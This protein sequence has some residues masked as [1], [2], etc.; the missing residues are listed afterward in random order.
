MT[1]ERAIADFLDISPDALIVIDATGKIALVNAQVE[2]IFGY[3]R[4]EL[5]NKP[6]EIL[7]PERFRAVHVTH[8]AHYFTSPRLRPMG[9]GLS[10]L[11]LRKNGQEFPVDI[12]LRPLD[13]SGVP[14]AIGAVRDMS[15]QRSAEQQV[16]ILR[17][18]QERYDTFLSMASH[19]LRTPLATMQVL[20]QLLSRMV[21]QGMER[22][23]E[24][25][26]RRETAREL[27]TEMFRQLERLNHLIGD[28]LDVSRV[29]AHQLSFDLEDIALYPLVVR[30]V[31]T[32]QKTTTTHTITVR[33]NGQKA[34]VVAD[35]HRIE[36]VLI[37]LLSNAI[38]YSPE[39]STVEVEVTRDTTNIT[40]HVRDH[41][42]GIASAQQAHLFERYYRLVDE[43]H[44]KYAGL[45]I[46]LYIASEIV[47]R[48]GGTM[49]V[50][51]AAGEG[52]IFS[53]TLP[54]ARKEHTL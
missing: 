12:S 3:S 44:K 35:P 13:L 46:G 16:V 22:S 51:S 50:E 20:T 19:E 17:E 38:K 41:G 24:Q 49:W 7:L 29:G 52:A 1:Q 37:N 34:I 25:Q 4:T 6:L 32:M 36:Q 33:E 21:D 39:A 9:R 28:L 27:L 30:T 43:K 15:A 14:H 26:T 53:F 48:H 23:E 45:G 8:R 10:L 2:A 11:G 5:L 40:V 31:S 18:Q 42:I 54:I 47:K